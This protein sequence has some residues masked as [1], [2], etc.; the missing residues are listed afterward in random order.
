MTR[1]EKFTS[2]LAPAMILLAGLAVT[3]ATIAVAQQDPGAQTGVRTGTFDGITTSTGTTLINPNNDPNGFTAFFADGL[4]RFQEIEDVSTNG[5]ANVVNTGLGPRFNFNQCAGC[6]AQP[7]V[8]GTGAAV[9]PQ[10]AAFGSCTSES[11]LS[12]TNVSTVTSGQSL[13]TPAQKGTI[14]CSSTNTVPSFITVNGPTR[15]ARF[16][17]LMNANGTVNTTIPSTQVPEDLFTVVGRPDAGTC[18][19]LAQPNFTAAQN[20]GNII[21]RIPTPLFGD[22]LFENLDDSTLI[23]NQQANLKNSLGIAGTF[24]RSGNDGTITKFGWKAQNKSLHIFSGEAYNV[25]MGITN[26]L[27]NNEKPLPEEE[28]LGTGLPASCLNLSGNGYP[29]DASN[30]T[31]TPNAAVLDDVSAFANFMRFL[32]PPPTGTVILNGAAVPAATIAAGEALFTSVGCAT[33]HNPTLGPTQVSNLVPALSQQTFHPF[34]DLELHDMGTGFADNIVQGN[35]GGDQFRTAPL[36][37]L[38]QRIF[39]LHDGR[40]LSV[41]AAIQNHESNGSE[42]NTVIANFNDLSATQKQE[43]IDF[44]RS[45]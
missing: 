29:E 20:A 8:G 30:P 4:S 32:A 40:D 28:L 2:F 6:H 26:L 5:N 33:C 16:P 38:G 24:N 3:Q 45:L 18:T 35:A 22:G 42:A 14:V 13:P 17:F 44:L 7:A 34:T 25:E 19:S 23:E 1:T 43:L 11:G 37:G 12:V 31:S 9:N 41:P 15:E 27:F 21:F 39:L 10:F 36:W